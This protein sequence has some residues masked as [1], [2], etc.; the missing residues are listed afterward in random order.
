MSD[1]KYDQA[2]QFKPSG[3]NVKDAS[4][5]LSLRTLIY[6]SQVIHNCQA[7]VRSPK[8]KVPK[9]RPK[10]HG[11]TRKSGKKVLLLKL[12]K[13]DPLDLTS[14]KKLTRW[15]VRSRTWGSPTCSRRSLSFNPNF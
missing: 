7:Q 11:L 10:G 3:I 12:A 13:N 2:L 9:S 6:S 14:P 15:T 1:T 8:S 4:S 5:S